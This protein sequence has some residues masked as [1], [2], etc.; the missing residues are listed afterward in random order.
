METANNLIDLVRALI[1][2]AEFLFVGMIA[3][4]I[5]VSFMP[6]DNPLHALL[7]SLT[8]HLA[9][10]LAIGIVALPVQPIPGVDV[11]YDLGSVVFLAYYWMTFAR[12]VMSDS[13]PLR[14][15]AP[16]I[17]GEAT[18]NPPQ[19]LMQRQVPASKFPRRT[20]G[21]FIDA[22]AE[23]SSYDTERRH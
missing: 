13:S 23:E 5:G 2:G 4:I 8:K 15:R 9:A 20:P 19:G 7:V 10:T 3:A 17:D 14:R 21:A 11:A 22:E 16:V 12:D 18:A 1:F 6:K